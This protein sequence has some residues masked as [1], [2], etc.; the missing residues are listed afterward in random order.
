RRPLRAGARGHRRGPPDRR[1][2]LDAPGVAA[3]PGAVRPLPDRWA[4]VV[5]R[6]RPHGRSPR[7]RLGCFHHRRITFTREKEPMTETTLST[8][9][10]TPE[11]EALI[12]GSL[13]LDAT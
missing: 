1:G 6:P 12:E 4:T 10:S 9:T 3:H 7:P 8:P 2:D 13:A 5:P 11:L